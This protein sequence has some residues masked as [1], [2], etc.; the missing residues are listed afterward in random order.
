MRSFNLCCYSV[1]FHL[2]THCARV[3]LYK[4]DDGISKTRFSTAKKDGYS[5]QFQRN[6][7]LVDA[8]AFDYNITLSKLKSNSQI[9]MQVDGMTGPNKLF[10]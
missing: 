3:F 6:E 10:L 2:K 5:L 4:N 9:V 8:E 1:K 7:I